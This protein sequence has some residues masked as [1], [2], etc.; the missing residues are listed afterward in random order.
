M[1]ADGI[2]QA[3]GPWQH[4]DGSPFDYAGW[5]LH[6]PDVHLAV[7]GDL[8]FQQR[9]IIYNVRHAIPTQCMLFLRCSVV[10]PSDLITFIVVRRRLTDGTTQLARSL[11]LGRMLDAAV[12]VVATVIAIVHS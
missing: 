5:K 12:V 1:R 9:C 3:S 8:A 6:E 2:Q 4:T 11:V 7:S 10:Y